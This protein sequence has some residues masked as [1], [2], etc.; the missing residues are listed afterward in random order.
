MFFKHIPI[1]VAGTLRNYRLNRLHLLDHRA[2]RNRFRLR[3]QRSWSN[4]HKIRDNFTSFSVTHSSS[5]VCD[6]DEW[7]QWIH[8]AVFPCNL[9]IQIFRYETWTFIQTNFSL[10][11]H[12]LGFLYEWCMFVHHQQLLDRNMCIGDYPWKKWICWL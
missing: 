12:L 1:T 10:H 8:I 4:L 3:S 5:C 11:Q 9:D 6:F 2:H 7:S